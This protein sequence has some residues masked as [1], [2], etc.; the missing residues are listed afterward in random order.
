MAILG[1]VI[2]DAV[3]QAGLFNGV[4]YLAGTLTNETCDSN[5]VWLWGA[6]TNVIVFVGQ[7]LTFT[8]YGHDSITKEIPPADGNGYIWMP[9]SLNRTPPP[10][11]SCF[12]GDVKIVMEDGSEKDIAD[13]RPGD[14]VLGRHGKINQVIGI[15]N[16]TLGSRSLFGF[17]GN[18]P[19]VTAEHPFLTDKGWQ[20]IDPLATSLENSSIPVT[21]LQA[22]DQLVKFQVIQVSKR[23]LAGHPEEG[24]INVTL[25]KENLSSIKA[26]KK[27]PDTPL[28]NLLL[29]GNNT[30][31]ANRY[32]VHNKGDH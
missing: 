30:Y 29:N 25:Y 14:F 22:N 4:V 13:L 6:H 10:P 9:V 2:K 19:F 27:D 1:G 15:E 17:N 8:A 24:H 11:N 31:F 26:Y 3:S 7:S 28:Y 21:A 23:Q 32:L 12:T 18:E 20:S 5:G 16:P